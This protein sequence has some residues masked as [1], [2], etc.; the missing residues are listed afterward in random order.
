MTM[1]NAIQKASVLIEALPYIQRFRGKEVV[2]KLGGSAMDNE[3]SL[4]T[5]L[6][7]VVFMEHVGMRPI[8]V[9]GGGPAISA[10]MKRRGLKPKFVKGH[11]VT[12]AETVKIVA[13]VL[14]NVI[15]ADIVRKMNELGGRAK[16]ITNEDR[17][18]IRARKKLMR[19]ANEKGEEEDV[20]LGFVGEVTSID[21]GM[22]LDMCMDNV[23]PVVAPIGADPEGNLLNLQADSLAS[24]IAE[25]LRPEKIVFLTD[26]PGILT[27]PDDESTL[28]SSLNEEEVQQLIRR[29]VIDGG[30]LPKVQGCL[31][32]LHAGVEKAHIVDG[33]VPHSLLLEIFTEKG[34]GTQIVS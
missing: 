2:V 28:V 30:M 29:G 8:L 18:T 24:F 9:H 15:N 4:K 6:Q 3:E 17:E 21:C 31:S 16:G 12:D 11:R 5:V 33:R 26:T 23:V 25:Q 27:K 14:G 20:D 22:L 1:Q 32:A 7:D 10:E 19:I 13:E 34:I